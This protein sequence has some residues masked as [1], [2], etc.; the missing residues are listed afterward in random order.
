MPAYKNERGSWNVKFYY[1]DWTGKRKQKKKEGFKTK[2][3]AQAFELDFLNKCENSVD[4]TFRNLVANYMDDCRVHLKPTTLANKQ[5]LIDTKILPYFGDMRICD[6]DISTVRK[7][8]NE[9]IS[10]ENGY[11]QTYLKTVHNQLSAIFNFAVKYYKLPSNPAA[12]CGSMGKKKAEGMQFWTKEEFDQFI[13]HV[14]DKP[15]SK[16]IFYLFFYSGIRE[17]ELLALT[18]NDFDFDKNTV[19]ITKNYARVN[20]QDIIQTPKTPK[21]KRTITL[22]VEIMEM[23]KEYSDMLYDYKPTDRLFPT[24]KSYLTREMV[25]GCK[26][27]GVKKIRIHDLRHSHASLLIELGFAPLLISE[28]LG[29]EN[30]ETT[31]NTYSHLYPNK[32]GEVAEILSNLMRNLDFSTILVRS[33]NQARRNANIYAIFRACFLCLLGIYE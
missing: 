20:N 18:L 15:M 14:S 25:R 31:L 26:L 5:F 1:T 19:S 13:P 2:K 22:P 30:V 6:I 32:H 23:V 8:Q 29:H 21:S 3:E 27:S 24:Q 12:A 17:G 28:R 11:S 7:W 10:H 4:I 33:K 9:L 16:V